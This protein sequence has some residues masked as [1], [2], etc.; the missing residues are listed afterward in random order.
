VHH[1]GCVIKTGTLPAICRAQIRLLGLFVTFGKVGSDKHDYPTALAL[2]LKMIMWL[3][4]T[5][6]PSF[7]VVIADP[8]TV[9]EEQGELCFSVLARG[10]KGNPSHG[11]VDQVSQQFMRTR[12]QMKIGRDMGVDL[13]AEDFEG[14]VKNKGNTIDDLSIK[15]AASHFQSVLRQLAA[16]TWRPKDPD[17]NK[18]NQT[19]GVNALQFAEMLDKKLKKDP[20]LWEVQVSE[21]D[22]QKIK[23]RAVSAVTNKGHTWVG[24]PEHGALWAQAIAEADPVIEPGDVKDNGGHARNQAQSSDDEEV[25]PAPKQRKR[26]RTVKRNSAVSDA[27]KKQKQDA[28]KKAGETFFPQHIQDEKTL[29][30]GAVE[31]LI[32]WKQY[33][34]RHDWTWE[35]S[36]TFL[37]GHEQLCQ[38]FYEWQGSA[39]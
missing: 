38:A 36:E 11:S 26:K 5:G 10:M 15:T 39:E 27:S 25:Q 23:R 9:N 2:N 34:D 35:P 13:G 20:K 17:I 8:M 32:E 28:K 24:Q 6:H 29:P 14:A 18:S 37:V 19:R 21:E 22:L 16:G 1:Y 30:G 3:R 7:A 31:F 33:P 12:E 4:E